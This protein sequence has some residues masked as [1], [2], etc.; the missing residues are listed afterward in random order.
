VEYERALETLRRML[1]AAISQAERGE[2]QAPDVASLKRRLRR[3][4]A[5]RRRGE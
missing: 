5:R 1:E 2:A 4:L 3:T